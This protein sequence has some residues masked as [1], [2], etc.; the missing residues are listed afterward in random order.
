[1]VL[2]NIGRKKIKIDA[3]ECCGLGKVI[4]LMFSRQNKARA[5]V[6]KFNRVTRMSI[7][8]IFCPKFL[9]IWMLKGKIIDYEIVDKTRFSIRPASLFDTLIEVP[10]NKKYAKVLKHFKTS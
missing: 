5:R 8:S 6:F 9:A 2:I 4:G 7:H 3:K 1:M 10:I